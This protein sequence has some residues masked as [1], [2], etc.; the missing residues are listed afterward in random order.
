[1]RVVKMKKFLLLSLL[2]FVSILSADS[3]K[4]VY[5]SGW[6]TGPLIAFKARTSPARKITILPSVAYLSTQGIYNNSW[7]IEPSERFFIVSPS[8]YM[9]YGITDKLE[10]GLNIPWLFNRHLKKNGN[11]LGDASF[12]VA[13]QLLEDDYGGPVY[14]TLF[15]VREYFPSGRYSNL[16]PELDG[17]DQTGFGL[18]Y[19][20]LGFNLQKIFLL[21]NARLLRLR[22]NIAYDLPAVAHV[23][24]LNAYGG[25]LGTKG[26]VWDGSTI[27][28][29]I[30]H[31]VQFTQNWVFACDYSYEHGGKAKFSG[32]PGKSFSHINSRHLLA[33]NGYPAWDSFNVSPAIEY[34]FSQGIGLIGGVWISVAGRNNPAFISP[35]IKFSATF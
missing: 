29:T 32:N 3:K 5:T 4:D 6:W 12:Q 21:A 1:M 33:N 10:C 7:K 20:T 13:Y 24:G 30:S 34:N 16:K 15:F 14:D 8:V 19:T 17:T 23:Q 31:E 2:I 18:F 26:K 22:I 9:S 11:G 35:I 28:L 27:Y 25:G